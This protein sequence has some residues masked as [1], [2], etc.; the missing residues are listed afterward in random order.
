M[1]IVDFY[2]MLG[3]VYEEGH[4]I[5]WNAAGILQISLNWSDKPA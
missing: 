4:W 1:T 3:S 5:G 2:S